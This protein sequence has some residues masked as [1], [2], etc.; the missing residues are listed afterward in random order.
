MVRPEILSSDVCKSVHGMR[1]EGDSVAPTQWGTPA[2]VVFHRLI[3][4]PRDRSLV[5]LLIRTWSSHI[6]A[7][8]SRLKKIA[9]LSHEAV[10]PYS[11][12]IRVKCKR[13]LT[14]PIPPSHGTSSSESISNRSSSKY[15][16]SLRLEPPKIPGHSTRAYARILQSRFQPHRP[17]PRP[18]SSTCASS[19]F[20][21]WPSRG[22]KIERPDRTVPRPS[23]SGLDPLR[24][25]Q[26]LLPRRVG[27]ERR[28]PIRNS[29]PITPLARKCYRD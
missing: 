15:R 24:L 21:L 7:V 17:F 13:E 6:A 23:V 28:K 3:F 22:G 29:R 14:A 16:S 4:Q 25:R 19:S 5:Q 2:M 10:A 12:L 27:C 11:F 26:Q 20:V 18:I 8:L 9:D 1:R